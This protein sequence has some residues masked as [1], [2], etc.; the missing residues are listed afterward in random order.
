MDKKLQD[1]LY[2]KYS[3]LFNQRKLPMAQTCMCWGFECGD[4]WYSLIDTLCGLLQWDIDHNKHKQIEVVQVKEKYGTLRFYTDIQ[5]DKQ[6]GMI[7]FAEY[8]S[9][10]ICEKC[11]SNLG[12]GQTKGS[13][14]YTRC[15]KCM[16][17]L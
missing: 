3:K 10:T 7:T 16:R 8:L 11:G 12:V 14:I 9:G 4:G 2:K 15:K 6:S 17:E 13:W 5:D 1:K